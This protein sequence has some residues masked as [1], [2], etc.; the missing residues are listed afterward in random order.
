ME[1]VNWFIDCILLVVHVF[2]S[3]VPRLAGLT[4]LAAAMG[5]AMLWVFGRTSNQERMKQVKRRVQAG[6]LELRIFVDEPAISL[7]AQRGLIA[8]NL[9]YLVLALRPALWMT[10]P[11]ALLVIHLEAFYGRAPLPLGEP[12]LVTMRMTAD[13]IPSAP[14]PVLITP[15]NVAILGAPVRVEAA[16]EVSWRI[17]PHSPVSAPPPVLITPSNV[18]ILGAPV[19]VEAAREVSW[20]ILPHSPVSDRLIFRY[21]GQEVA[22]WMEAGDRQRYV[23]GRRVRSGWET[24][25]S[26]G[27]SRMRS[28]FAEWIEIRYPAADLRI[29]GLHVNWLAWFVIVSMVAALLLKK[30]FGV[31]I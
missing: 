22:K 26:P 11:I 28:D 19:R 25:L 9:N 20:R 3:F 7:R 4:V 29:F 8:A 6:L 16:R 23:T 17:L 14:P 13:W 18:A 21:N 12:A 2:F 27:E 24:L 31:V 1:I 5:A 15:S 10:V 30:R